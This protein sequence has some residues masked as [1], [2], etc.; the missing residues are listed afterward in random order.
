MRPMGSTWKREDAVRFLERAK[1]KGIPHVDLFACGSI[2]NAIVQSFAFE[3][4]GSCE[5]IADDA[6]LAAQGDTAGRSGSLRF[7]LVAHKSGKQWG[8]FPFTVDAGDAQ[9]DTEDASVRGLLVEAIRDKREAYA[10]A[11][12]HT[13]SMFERFETFVNTL[14][15][16]VEAGEEIKLKCFELFAQLSDNKAARDREDEK[17][18]LEVE[19]QRHLIESFKPALGLGLAK[20][21]GP[22]S[23]T[24]VGEK[25]AEMISDAAQLMGVLESLSEQQFGEIFPKLNMTQQAVLLELAQKRTAAREAEEEARKN[26]VGASS[27]VGVG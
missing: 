14:A 9:F 25:N 20:I 21:L 6:F 26:G 27:P 24:N 19:T 22:A 17:L 11:L 3:E 16:Q 8:R 23:P 4:D 1:K 13:Q 12:T 18:R 7:E 5:V 15:K 2:D 10:M